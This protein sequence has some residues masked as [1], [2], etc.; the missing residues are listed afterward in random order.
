MRMSICCVDIE[1]IHL[2]S[3]FQNE[4]A[5]D[6]IFQQANFNTFVFRNRVKLETYNVSKAGPGPIKCLLV[7]CQ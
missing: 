1:P 6:E 5:F 3:Q 7:C 4:A 2:F